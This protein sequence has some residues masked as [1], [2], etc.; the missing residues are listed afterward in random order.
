MTL[1]QRRRALFLTTVAI[2]TVFAVTEGMSLLA[3]RLSRPFLIEEI[4]TTRDILREQ[5]ERIQRLL[6]RDSSHMLAP[7]PLLGWRYRAGYHD[8]ANTMNAQD[9]RS[10]RQYTPQPPR[11]VL[12]VAAFGDSF[13][14]GNEVADSDAWPALVEQ[15]FPRVEVLNYGVGG[16]GV[17]QAY[18]RFCTE[19]T[20][21]SP[22]IVIIGFATDDLR[23]V[24]NV[25]RRFISNREIPLVK[26]RFA[27]DP[28]GVLV[29]RPNPL[30]HL[31]DYER[32]LR[33]PRDIARLG[34]NDYWYRAAIYQNPVYDYSATVRLLTNLWLR[35]YERYF[36]PD[37]LFRHGQFSPSSTAFRIQTLLFK[38]FA[39]AVPA[40]GARPIV[41]TF[42][43]RQSVAAAPQGRQTVF[44]PLVRE[45]AAAGIDHIDL[46]EAF[47]DP[48]A[49]GDVNTWFMRGGHYSRAGNRVVAL[50]LGWE[51]LARA[52][53]LGSDEDL[54]RARDGSG[55]RESGACH[56]EA[57]Q[58]GT[59]PLS[60]AADPVARHLRHSGAP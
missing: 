10:T 18:L 47:V 56:A 2:A 1:S 57:V 37:R 25:Y 21:L 11:G 8:S 16:Y 51:V 3:I 17:D 58:Q 44:A 7:D 38:K 45:V 40:A 6:E 9:L 42:P 33:S 24:V 34:A 12:R 32:Y 46:T 5:S 48:T 15:L 60:S 41:V 54:L 27:L 36:A 26:P 30:P 43:D 19:G 59:P 20:A 29:L 53:S 4:R 23:R 55:P 22:R 35:V 50:R 49:L 31:S 52:V 13:V 28:R 14:Y 39:A